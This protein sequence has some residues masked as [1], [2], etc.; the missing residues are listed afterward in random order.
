M[1]ILNK[2][3]L[4]L[5]FIPKLTLIQTIWEIKIPTLEGG[6]VKKKLLVVKYD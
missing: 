5:F 1:A 4:V 2:L 3:M 6:R